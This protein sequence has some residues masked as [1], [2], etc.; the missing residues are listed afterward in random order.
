MTSKTK[1]LGALNKY[2]KMDS[3]YDIILKES[4]RDYCN[5]R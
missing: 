5:M 2:E 1:N 3:K 4:F